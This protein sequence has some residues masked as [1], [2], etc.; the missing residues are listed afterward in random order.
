MIRCRVFVNAVFSVAALIIVIAGTSRAQEK[1]QVPPKKVA[2]RA[3]R[4][5]DGKSET[6][7]VNALI[8]VEGDKIISV[9]PGGSAPAGVQLIDLSK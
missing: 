7:I 9:T 6:P 8:L 3:G 5:I 4:L 2:V 1:T